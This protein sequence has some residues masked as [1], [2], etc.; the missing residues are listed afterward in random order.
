VKHNVTKL[1]GHETLWCDV[2]QAV[3]RRKGKSKIKISDRMVAKIKDKFIPKDYQ[4]NMFR[5]LQNMRQK[6]MSVKKY[7]K[8]FYKLNIRAGHR[9]NDEEKVSRYINGLWYEIQ[10]EISMIMMRTLEDD[11]CFLFCKLKR[12]YILP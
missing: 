1:R 9:E 4:L 3:R 10:D 6:G 7:T 8:E 12:K 2:L 5:R 11:C